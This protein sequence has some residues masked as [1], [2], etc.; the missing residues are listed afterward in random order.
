MPEDNILSDNLESVANTN[1]YGMFMTPV[2]VHSLTNH[3]QHKQ[4]ILDY[5]AALSPD[6][7]KQSPRKDINS[8]VLQLG[9]LNVLN[10]EQFVSLKSD[11]L[12]G[13]V[14]INSKALCYELGDNP[15]VI[16]STIELGNEGSLYAPHEQS[17]CLYS[18]TYFVNWNANEHSPLKFKR[19]VS[20]THYPVI[21]YNQT[22]ITPFN[23]L[24]GIVPI[25][26]GEICLY[27]ANLTRGYEPN[28]K[29]NRITITFN[30]AL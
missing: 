26:E 18:G 20:S 16:D 21:Q 12:Q 27:P 7:V 3:K 4:T 19:D 25:T 6:D 22:Q 11:I 17:N 28:T 8:G 15:N 1:V 24:D 29:G 5:I 2:G 14:D 23:M 13:I 10:L 9:A 30:V